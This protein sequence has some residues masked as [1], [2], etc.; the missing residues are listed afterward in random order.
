MTPLQRP[1]RKSALLLLLLISILG[2]ADASYL[3]AKFYQG[4]VPPCSIVSGCEEVT[5]SQY[6]TI[7][8]VPVSLTGALYYL[9]FIILLVVYLDRGKDAFFRAAAWLSVFGFLFSLWLLSAQLFLIGAICLYCLF[10]FTTST[11][12]FITSTSILGWGRHAI[13]NT[14]QPIIPIYK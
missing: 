7:L 10:S 8:G 13:I 3:A 5:T 11:V 2:F 6:A 12:I 4:K 1:V 14:N 9:A